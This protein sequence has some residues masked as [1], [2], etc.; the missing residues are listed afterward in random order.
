MWHQLWPM[1]RGAGY[2]QNYL[3]G[4]GMPPLADHLR[5]TYAPVLSGSDTQLLVAR[6]W[7]ERDPHIERVLREIPGV[8]G[9]VFS[10]FRHDNRAASARGDWTAGRLS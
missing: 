3:D 1:H 5:E 4:S 2:V 6:Q 8:S 7:H 10:T 9:L